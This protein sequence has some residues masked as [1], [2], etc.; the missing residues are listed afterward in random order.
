MLRQQ[1]HPHPLHEAWNSIRWLRISWLTPTHLLHY[2]TLHLVTSQK[3]KKKRW[4]NDNDSHVFQHN[5]MTVMSYYMKSMAAMRYPG[6]R[7]RLE[8]WWR[9]SCCYTCMPPSWWRNAWTIWATGADV[10]SQGSAEIV[11]MSMS[12]PVVVLLLRVCVCIY[13]ADSE[14]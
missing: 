14:G 5:T 3:R 10:H 1:H 12:L 2:I 7:A 8:P 4:I 6:V 13:R 11:W 9:L